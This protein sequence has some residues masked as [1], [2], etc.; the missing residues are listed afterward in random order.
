MGTSVGAPKRSE[1]ISAARDL[2]V[3][4]GLPH[5][6]T[7]SGPVVCDTRVLSGPPCAGVVTTR[8]ALRLL[9]PPPLHWVAPGRLR[10]SIV[11][12]DWLSRI[13]TQHGTIWDA[14]VMKA[15]HRRT[16]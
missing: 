8:H 16:N 15:Q 1:Q 11:N 5:P 2:L 10:T 6:G 14:W 3:R 9:P 7:P 12:V 13:T 4:H